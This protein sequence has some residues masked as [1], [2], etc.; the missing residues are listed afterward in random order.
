[1]TGNAYLVS[2]E[3]GSLLVD[4]GRKSAFRRLKRNIASL[5]PDFKSIQFLILTHSHYDHCNNAHEI[6]KKA[7]CRIMM[8]ACEAEFAHSGS[9]PLPE[10]TN[11]LTRT[12]SSLGKKCAQKVFKFSPF[13]P[14]ILVEDDLDL[15]NFGFNI[16]IIHTK[17][18]SKGSI[19]VLV[20][21]EIAI[22]GDAMFG[23][24]KNSIFPPFADDIPEMIKSW[25]KLLETGCQIFLPG[26]GNVINREL[27]QNESERFSRNQPLQK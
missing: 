14:D 7:G 17:G 5:N 15:K 18:H 6:Q 8:S 11:P 19:S 10:G 3:N 4:T 27:V 2:S 13:I 20:D 9:S 24:F 16:R 21:N 26:H 1:M 23:V 25:G 12:I 22:V